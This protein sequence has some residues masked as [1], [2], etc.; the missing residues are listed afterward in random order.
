M[1][2][3]AKKEIDDT[4]KQV[5]DII[6]AGLSGDNV[7]RVRKLIQEKSEKV[8]KMGEEAFNR[9]FEQI[10]PMLDQNPQVKQFVEYVHVYA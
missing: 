4:W 1:G 7:D 5:N 9:G 10:K 6:K 3:E 8:K 2:P